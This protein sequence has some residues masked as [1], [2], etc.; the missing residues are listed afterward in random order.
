M[1]SRPNCST[2]R[3]TSARGNAGRGDVSGHREGADLA[4]HGLGPR[5]VA[6][7]DRHPGA[8]LDQADRRGASQPA[9]RAGDQRDAAGEVLWGVG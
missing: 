4:R 2:V 9:R 3:A 5:L 7:V 1:S 6:D 8:A